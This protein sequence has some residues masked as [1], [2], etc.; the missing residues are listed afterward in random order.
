VHAQQI[1]RPKQVGFTLIELMIVVAIVGILGAA[2]VFVYQ[3]YLVRARV[4][5]ALSQVSPARITVA[6]NAMNGVADLSKGFSPPAATKNLAAMSID[7]GN[8]IITV[9]LS[10]AAG[11]GT[12]LLVPYNGSD[13]APVALSA[14]TIPSG[15]LKWRCRADGSAFALGGAGTLRAIYAPSECR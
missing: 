7:S 5:D 4:S 11:N 14:G 2:S 10:A 9:T 1:L 13:A 12:L 3:D 8:G 15:V 6:E